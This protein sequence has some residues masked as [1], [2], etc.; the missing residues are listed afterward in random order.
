MKNKH[1]HCK[2]STWIKRFWHDSGLWISCRCGVSFN[3]STGASSFS[4]IWTNYKKYTASAHGCVDVM[5]LIHKRATYVLTSKLQTSSIKWVCLN[6]GVCPQ[7][8]MWDHFGRGK[9]WSSIPVHWV[10]WAPY[11]GVHWRYLKMLVPQIIPVMFATFVYW[12]PS[13]KLT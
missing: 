13:G 9:W 2:G 1:E 3:K 12:F 10:L 5:R 4:L 8:A 11:L 6:M 7:I